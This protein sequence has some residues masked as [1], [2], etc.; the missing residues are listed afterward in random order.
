MSP[1]APCARLPSS[2]LSNDGATARKFSNSRLL[3]HAVR[4]QIALPPPVLGAVT[5]DDKITV[6][7]VMRLPTKPMTC[8]FICPDGHCAN[9]P[10]GEP[11][12]G[13]VLPSIYARLYRNK[14]EDYD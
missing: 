9:R 14:H 7:I 13:A 1:A 3:E 11:M 4:S 8:T 5:C 2:S 6:R 10:R 12:A